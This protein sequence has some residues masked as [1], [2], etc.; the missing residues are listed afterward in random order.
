MVRR[1]L[2]LSLERSGLPPG[3]VQHV[4]VH[5]TSTRAGDR[6]EAGVMRSVFGDGSDAPLVSATK[7]ITGHCIGASGAIE[8]VATVL[9]LRDGCVHQ[10]QNLEDVDPDCEL[11]HV[12]GPPRTAELEHAVAASYGFGGHNAVLSLRRC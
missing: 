4:N 8:V 12:I 2:Q 3:E 7:S 11:N 9:A 10:T 6:V 5:G 1:A